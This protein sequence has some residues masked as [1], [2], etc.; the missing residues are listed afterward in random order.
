MEKNISF[1]QVV[2]FICDS[3]CVF[4]IRILL[5]RKKIYSKF[6]YGRYT[7]SYLQNFHFVLGRNKN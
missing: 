2:L 3:Y 7:S 4:K 6:T 1:I 5:F